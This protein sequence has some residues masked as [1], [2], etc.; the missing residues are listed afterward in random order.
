MP[1]LTQPRLPPGWELVDILRCRCGDDAFV[2]CEKSDARPEDTRYVTWEADLVRGGCYRGHYTEDRA[3][4]EADLIR[5]HERH[6]G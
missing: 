5:R 1:T 2:L 3:E 6:G 4:A